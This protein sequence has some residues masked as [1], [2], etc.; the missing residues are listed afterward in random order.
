MFAIVPKCYILKSSKSDDDQEAKKMKGVS[1]RLNNSIYLES[2]KSCLF[3]S[4]VPVSGINH[5][6]MVVK[7]HPFSNT[8]QMIK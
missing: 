2:Y 5:C 6:F 7:S 1:S 4:V 3:K 8:S